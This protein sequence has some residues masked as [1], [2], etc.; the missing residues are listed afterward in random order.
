LQSRTLAES[1]KR[2]SWAAGAGETT[3]TAETK[4]RWSLAGRC[5]IGDGRGDIAPDEVLCCKAEKR[6]SPRM[7][8][9]KEK[10]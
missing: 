2:E 9:G 1:D 3:P 10:F 8:C 4:A 7:S 5:S 6:G